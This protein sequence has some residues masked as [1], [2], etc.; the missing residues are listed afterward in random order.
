MHTED[1]KLVQRVINKERQ[2]AEAFFEGFFPRLFRF[3]AL[4]MDHSNACEDVVQEAMI[5]A[6][7]NLHT[8]RG[9]AALFTWLCQISRNEISNLKDYTSTENFTS[10][11]ILLIV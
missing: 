7:R 6:M 9:E 11:N 10:R 2:A 8:Y 5:K 4:R 3:V 1:L